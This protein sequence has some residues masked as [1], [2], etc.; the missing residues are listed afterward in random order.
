M[1]SIHSASNLIPRNQ[2]PYPPWFKVVDAYGNLNA[3]TSGVGHVSLPFQRGSTQ[4]T[5]AAFQAAGGLLVP[6]MAGFSFCRSKHGSACLAGSISTHVVNGVG[7]F[8]E[9]FVQHPGPGFRF[10]FEFTG[11]TVWSPPFN[12][13][14]APPRVTGISFSETFSAITVN[15]D[16]STNLAG[17]QDSTDCRKI[18]DYDSV[19]KLGV[20]AACSWPD[21]SRLLATLGNKAQLLPGDVLSFTS[22]A[23]ILSSMWWRPIVLAGGTVSNQRIYAPDESVLTD[24]ANIALTSCPMPRLTCKSVMLPERVREDTVINADKD[25]ATSDIEHMTIGSTHFIAVANHCEGRNCYFDPNVA[26]SGANFDLDSVIYE[27]QAD[28][29]LREYQRIPT[30]GASDLTGFVLDDALT[31][32]GYAPRQFLAVANYISNVKATRH[33]AATQIWAWD[34]DTL[35]FALRQRIPTNGGMS[36]NVLLHDGNT[37]ICV[38]NTGPESYIKILRWVAGSFRI[39]GNGADYGWEEGQTFGWVP[40]LFL[41][42][43]QTIP[44]DGAMQAVLYHAH[45]EAAMFL[46][47]SN[48]QSQG[49]NKVHVEIYRW[50][51]E[52]CHED[53]S[54]SFLNISCFDQ[55]LALPALGARTVTPFV[56]EGNN[57]MAVANYFNGDISAEQSVHYEADSFVYSVDYTASKESFKLHQVRIRR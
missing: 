35:Q 45:G 38:T 19:L 28:G 1:G 14:P 31:T 50:R 54:A 41:E 16:R 18:F 6:Y 22:S 27:W 2:H 8:T 4:Q 26:F 30:Y 46:A 53:P 29:N 15:F 48:Y 7:Y 49:S 21:A 11:L 36:V 24:A 25:V 9:L 47:A 34:D 56:V 39:D 32:G 13:L 12:V 10:E 52:V 42:P 43:L 37:Y 17:M 40:G 44:T 51:E 57:Y 5:A 55:I 20:G 23:V 3:S 33:L